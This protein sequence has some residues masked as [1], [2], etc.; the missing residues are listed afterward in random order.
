[1]DFKDCT[2][3][4]EIQLKAGVEILA[5][6]SYRCTEK[7]KL[8]EFKNCNFDIFKGKWKQ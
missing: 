7:H 6:G 5:F 8:N 1:M 3:K 4:L 2:K